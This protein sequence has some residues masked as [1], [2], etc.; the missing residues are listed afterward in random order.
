MLQLLSKKGLLFPAIFCF[1]M[2]LSSSLRAQ[3]LLNSDSAFKAGS[4]NSGRLW[5]YVFGDYYYKSHSDT[6]NRGGSNQYTG[7]PKNRNAFQIR[8]A[9]LGYNYNIT[10]K[11]S[12]ELLLAAET[13]ATSAGTLSDN[14]LAFYIKLANLR[15]KDIWKGTDLLL[16]LVATPSFSASSEPAWGYRSI[17]KTLIDKNGTPSF[18]LGAK[19]EG[20]FDPEKGNFGYDLM[21]GNGSGARLEN[22]NYKWFY[23]DV[24]GKFLNKK[25]LVNLNADYQQMAPVAG[26]NH[27]R[28]MIKGF[29]SYTVPK[30]T[31][32]IEAYTNTLKNDNQATQISTGN[33]D[34]LTV[35][36][37]GVSVFARGSLVKDKLYFFAR[38]DNS[39]PDNKIDNIK[40]NKYVGNTSGYNDPSTKE[41]FITAG[42]DF[43][44]VKSV[45]LM[46]NIW[47]NHYTNQGFGSKYDSYDLVYRFTFY[48]VFGK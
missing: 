21:V 31:V 26:K 18:D 17:E 3:F 36:A 44:P 14:R 32:G 5:G 2:L 22:D 16:G 40:Y 6:L 19:L 13:G 35:N 7:I 34:V 28:N 39:N 15:I 4:P 30:F 37:R 42:L 27:S 1:G 48:Y 46:P 24:W 20:K 23:A 9:Y 45:H 33:V 41:Q 43:T 12:A 38:Y 8:R 25:L 11:F 47:Y 10:K 29:V